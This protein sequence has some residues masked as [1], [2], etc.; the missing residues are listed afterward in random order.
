MITLN[1]RLRLLVS[2]MKN[3]MINIFLWKEKYLIWSKNF[4][5]KNQIMVKTSM[6]QYAIIYQV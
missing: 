2:N 4:N 5:I 6:I 1:R 3:N